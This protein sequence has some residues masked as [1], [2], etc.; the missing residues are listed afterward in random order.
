MKKDIWPIDGTKHHEVGRASLYTNYAIER[1]LNGDQ[2]TTLIATKGMGK[3]LLLRAKKK[4]LE[5]D[6]EGVLI[7]PRDAEYDEPPTTWQPTP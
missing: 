2:H 6:P 5:T 1:F 3:T 4:I 7:I